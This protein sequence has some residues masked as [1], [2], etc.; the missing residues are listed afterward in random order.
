MSRVVIEN[1]GGARTWPGALGL[2]FAAGSTEDG[3][4]QPPTL[5]REWITMGDIAKNPTGTEA[6]MLRVASWAG[7][8]AKNIPFGIDFSKVV[9]TGH[10]PKPVLFALGAR[11]GLGPTDLRGMGIQHLALVGYANDYSQCNITRAPPTFLVPSHCTL[12][13]RSFASWPLRSGRGIKS[14]QVQYLQQMPL[15]E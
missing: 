3:V 2:S 11:E 4:P 8:I 13:S 6:L 1:G 9:I 15:N 10:Y 7:K 5:L 12:I 14:G